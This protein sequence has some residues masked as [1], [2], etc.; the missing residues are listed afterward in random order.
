MSETEENQEYIDGIVEKFKSLQSGPERL[1][2]SRGVT[3]LGFDA[4]A[5]AI[6]F[7]LLMNYFR[8]VQL[9]QQVW[10]LVALIV[11]KE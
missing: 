11:R 10:N 3:G 5:S 2:L 4:D 6:G 9:E 8:I 1:I 7:V